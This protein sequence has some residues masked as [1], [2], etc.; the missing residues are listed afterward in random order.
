MPQEVGSTPWF[1]VTLGKETTVMAKPPQ[2][3]PAY[4]RSPADTVTDSEAEK[5]R[6]PQ[7]V[8]EPALS[9]APAADRD[10]VVWNGDHTAL[11]CT[12]SGP[13]L[14]GAA[15]D[16]IEMPDKYG[17]IENLRPMGRLR[18]GSIH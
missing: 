18:G 7:T 12:K 13:F 3:I 14:D 1:A 4:A 5:E 16:L 15:I 9:T 10:S 11:I 17:P 6:K 8:G 2:L